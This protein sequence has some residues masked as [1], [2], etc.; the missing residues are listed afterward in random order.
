M[1]ITTNCLV[2]HN[3]TEYQPG[4]EIPEKKITQ[5]QLDTLVLAGAVTISAPESPADGGK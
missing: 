3:K 1:T 5:E 2:I 4:A